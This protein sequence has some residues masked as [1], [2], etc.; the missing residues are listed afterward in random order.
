MGFDW[1]KLQEIRRIEG[2][3]AQ[4]LKRLDRIIQ[5]L[6]RAELDRIAPGQA[7][8]NEMFSK[9]LEGGGSQVSR[10]SMFQPKEGDPNE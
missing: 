4:V 8:R 2:N 3:F 7:A 9:L 5:L 10:K 6:E 1:A